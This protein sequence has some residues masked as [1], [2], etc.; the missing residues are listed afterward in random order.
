MEWPWRRLERRVHRFVFWESEITF[1]RLRRPHLN[2]PSQVMITE[3]V[4]EASPVLR[5]MRLDGLDHA[6]VPFA[7]RHLLAWLGGPK[8]GMVPENLVSCIKVWFIPLTKL[9]SVQAALP[10]LPH[11]TDSGAV[12]PDN[13]RIQFQLSIIKM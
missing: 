4:E 12:L 10:A 6:T 3:A 13:D 8:P 1:W 7:E 2:I 11:C 5:R 9:I